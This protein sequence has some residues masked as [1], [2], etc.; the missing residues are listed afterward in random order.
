MLLAVAFV[1]GCELSF[2]KLTRITAVARVTAADAVVAAACGEA[3][4]FVATNSEPAAL[5]GELDV[6]SDLL[7]DATKPRNV[8]L[9]EPA[10]SGEHGMLIDRA[11]SCEIVRVKNDQLTFE[12]A[13]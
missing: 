7:V 12:R 10:I 9:H 3:R 1:H 2:V 5:T 11:A 8:C 6:L 4:S 13:L